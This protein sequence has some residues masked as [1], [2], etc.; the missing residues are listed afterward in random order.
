MM[1][2]YKDISAEDK[3]KFSL[4]AMEYVFA[5]D[6]SADVESRTRALKE[7][8]QR[9]HDTFEG[10]PDEAVAHGFSLAYPHDRGKFKAAMKAFRSNLKKLKKEDDEVAAEEAE[11]RREIHDELI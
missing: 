3:R 8:G 10:D 1:T 2:K 6:V 9:L 11:F 7:C 5:Y 4:E